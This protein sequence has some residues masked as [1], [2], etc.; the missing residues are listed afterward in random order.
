[1]TK[2]SHRIISS[3]NYITQ[4]IFIYTILLCVLSYI[5]NGIPKANA[6]NLQ[7][8]PKTNHID[9]STL[10]LP[11]SDLFGQYWQHPE[12]TTWQLAVPIQ[13]KNNLDKPIHIQWGNNKNYLK[14]SRQAITFFDE[15][16][17]KQFYEKIQPNTHQ[18]YLVF[19]S[20]GK[21]RHHIQI[22]QTKQNIPLKITPYIHWPFTSANQNTDIKISG[23]SHQDINND[24]L[25]K[26]VGNANVMSPVRKKRNVIGQVICAHD[27]FW[28]LDLLLHT[29][30]ELKNSGTDVDALLHQKQKG[31]AHISGSLPEQQIKR[32]PYLQA[33]QSAALLKKITTGTDK[34]PILSSYAAAKTC[35]IPLHRVISSRKP[36]GLGN[37]A[38]N[39]C[40]YNTEHIISIYT[41]IYGTTSSGQWNQSHFEHMVSTILK[42]GKTGD[43]HLSSDDEN[44]LVAAIELQRA[45]EHAI[46]D[47]YMRELGDDYIDYHDGWLAGMAFSYAQ[48][49]YASYVQSVIHSATSIDN[50][51]FLSP[52]E[53]Q[54]SGALGT[55]QID[56]DDFDESEIPHRPARIYH[57]GV[58]QTDTQQGFET[59]LISAAHM[60]PVLHQELQQVVRQWR[61]DYDQISADYDEHLGSHN[62]HMRSLAQMFDSTALALTHMNVAL[63]G[64][65]VPVTFYPVHQTYFSIT[66][67]QG[68]I[69]NL[70]LLCDHEDSDEEATRWHIE[71]VLTEPH[72]TMPVDISTPYNYHEGAIRGAGQAA[73][74]NLVSEAQS[75]GIES[76]NA[77]VI[78]IPSALMFNR[79]GFTLINPLEPFVH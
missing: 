42:T 63:S 8:Q 75:M 15:T 27:A 12:L 40:V 62:L 18:L 45:I 54:H 79:I 32:P 70:I 7:H 14:I 49:A 74:R 5:S 16:Q 35:F 17:H 52:Q 4:H 61:H 59:T 48:S 3:A 50:L 24:T 43:P 19:E 6:S 60:D 37:D 20:N 44:E 30:C 77:H 53:I 65:E 29:Q 41:R 22:V 46:K 51:R 71:F 67:Y 76:I 55:Y 57:D 36:R 68:R 33:K 66:R 1:M 34:H 21:D 13:I 25:I 56:V 64:I 39:D 73:L 69:V 78:T 2:K 58:W 11:F 23:L 28:V 38:E 72:S 10:N 31:Y 26:V 47:N 9:N